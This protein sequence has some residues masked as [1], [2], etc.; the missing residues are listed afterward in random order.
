[1]DTAGTTSDEVTGVISGVSSTGLRARLGDKSPFN[2]S[3]ENSASANLASS[4]ANLA[5]SFAL[6]MSLSALSFICQL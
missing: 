4:S 5:F 3:C 1:M 2:K 6:E